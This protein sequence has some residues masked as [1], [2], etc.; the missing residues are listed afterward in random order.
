MKCSDI[1]EML[2]AYANSE[3]S[4]TQREAVEEHLL[5]CADCQATLAEYVELR[6]R[7]MALREMPALSDITEATMQ[8]IKTVG[9]SKR[10][11]TRKIRL[12]L[13][14][15]PTVAVVIALLILQPWGSSLGPQRVLAKTYT[16]FSEVKSF[17]MEFSFSGTSEDE[18][19]EATGLLEYGDSDNYYSK[20]VVNGQPVE[21]II[22]VGDQVFSRV[23][24]TNNTPDYSWLAPS[25]EKTQE[26]LQSLVNVELL[27]DET[28]DGKDCFHYR[29]MVDFASGYEEQIA[30]LDPENP[31]YE[32][33]KESLER[34]AEYL[35]QLWRQ[36]FEIWI[37]K[38]DY[39]LRRKIQFFQVTPPEPEEQVTATMTTRYYDFN[40]PIVIAP[41]LDDN[42]E[43]L[44]GWTLLQ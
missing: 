23:A 39:L 40:E 1:S 14:S 36:E 20:V 18:Y 9:E 33:R 16:A 5:T 24:V 3:L 30:Q 12:A 8:R 17:R 4:S 7:L 35:R 28:I 15:V 31:H 29:G 2:S 11:V 10:V 38:D 6:Q 37:G 22:V 44:P 13:V 27:P 19:I 43:L 42:G 21:E 41:P 25:K 26:L 32:L 34:S